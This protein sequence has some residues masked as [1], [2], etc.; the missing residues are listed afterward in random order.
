MQRRWLRPIKKAISSLDLS[1]DK[2]F[3]QID[4]ILSELISLMCLITENNSSYKNAS[5]STITNAGL[6]V[7]S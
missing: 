1:Q 4:S 2:H 6:I 7:Y 3:Y 5:Q